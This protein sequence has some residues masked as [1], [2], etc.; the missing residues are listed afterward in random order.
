MKSGAMKKV[1]L[2]Y[3]FDCPCLTYRNHTVFYRKDLAFVSIMSLID[4][5]SSP[6]R[7]NTCSKKSKQ[8]IE[9]RQVQIDELPRTLKPISQRKGIDTGQGKFRQRLKERR[10]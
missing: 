10:R 3:G 2:T 9:F 4:L 8:I 1:Y 6:R 5:L 7:L